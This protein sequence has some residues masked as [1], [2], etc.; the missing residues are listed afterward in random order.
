[1]D[2]SKVYSSRTAHEKKTI[3]Q[4]L[5]FRKIEQGENDPN[6][7]KDTDLLRVWDDMCREGLIK[8]SRGFLGLQRPKYKMTAVGESIRRDNLDLVRRTEWDIRNAAET[9]KD[10][11]KKGAYEADKEL[12]RKKMKGIIEKVTTANSLTPAVYV[13]L[14]LIYDGALDDSDFDILSKGNSHDLLP[15]EY[16]IKRHYKTTRI[17]D[18]YHKFM[19]ES[20]FDVE[21]YYWICLT[22]LD[23]YY[24][25]VFDDAFLEGEVVTDIEDVA[26]PE[27]DVYEPLVEEE[28]TA[29]MDEEIQE[30]I[31]MTHIEPEPARQ[32]I[33]I[34]PEPTYQEPS[35]SELSHQSS[36]D[37]DSS[38]SSW[39]SS[40]S[41]DS[42][43]SYDSGGSD[44]G[45][46]DD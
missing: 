44:S 42:G 4:A 14:K 2:F 18:R 24:E 34:A 33:N 40:D 19:T 13:L 6:E 8:S 17:A 43:S 39:G 12:I 5:A 38:K 35:Y 32:T 26:G 27:P 16:A 20:Y 10:N 23:M 11:M 29:A 30:H 37:E 15:L 31:E 22:L 46:S 3:E 28:A 45:G 1:M 21:D 25:E 41:Y 7:T 36:C 9:F